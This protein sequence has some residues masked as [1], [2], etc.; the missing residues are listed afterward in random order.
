MI[1]SGPEILAQIE[2]G[3]ISID[4]FNR[5]H[6][7]PASVDLTLGSEVAVYHQFT[8]RE[9]STGW[10]STAEEHQG[11]STGERL[12]PY[13]G[14]VAYDSKKEPSVHRYTIDPERGWV[15]NPG[16][17]YLMH[18]AERVGTN[19]FVPILDGK[20]SIGRLFIKVHETAGFGD[21]GFN[22]QYTLEVTAEFPVIVYAG[23]RICQIRFHAI[24]GEIQNYQNNGSYTGKM[25][26]GPIPSQAFRSAFKHE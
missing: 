9:T 6:V 18:T 13:R 14:A 22:G 11:T 23:M 12:L 2:Q 26:T 7:N 25:A 1:L 16:V 15:L 3:R 24:Q 4:P 19:H 8:A 5:G 20:S 10:H 21:P 17:G